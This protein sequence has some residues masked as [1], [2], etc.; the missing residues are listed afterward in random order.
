[1]VE[2]YTGP[3]LSLF[4]SS[5]PAIASPAPSEISPK[6]V[7]QRSGRPHRPLSC[8][9]NVFGHTEPSR[10]NVTQPPAR[11]LSFGL[12][13]E[14]GTN[15][16]NHNSRFISPGMAAREAGRLVAHTLTPKRSE[17]ERAAAPEAASKRAS[18]CLTLIQ[19]PGRF[20]CRTLLVSTHR[21]PLSLISIFKGLFCLNIHFLCAICVFWLEVIRHAAALC[22]WALRFDIV[23][24]LSCLIDR[25]C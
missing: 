10:E 18:P 12:P 2:L 5:P 19:A 23:V 13:Q 3:T 22:G 4:M 17:E 6:A 1:M 11:K 7:G 25:R 15:T 20:L 16:V 21:L 14:T 9:G 8:Y 24:H